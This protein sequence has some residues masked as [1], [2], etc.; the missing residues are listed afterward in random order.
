MSTHVEDHPNLSDGIAEKL[1][2]FGAKIA[3]EDWG[4]GA[5]NGGVNRVSFSDACQIGGSNPDPF[6]TD[7]LQAGPEGDSVGAADDSVKSESYNSRTKHVKPSKS[8]TVFFVKSP[9]LSV[10]D[11]ELSALAFRIYVILIDCSTDKTGG[12]E[13]TIEWLASA[14]GSHK[15]SVIRATRNL[16]EQGYIVK[17]QRAREGMKRANFYG[18]K[19]FKDVPTWK[20]GGASLKI[21]KPPVAGAA[22]VPDTIE[23]PIGE[24]EEPSGAAGAASPSNGSK[25]A[26]G[27]TVAPPVVKPPLAL[28]EPLKQETRA[29]GRPPST[30]QA[31]HAWGVFKTVYRLGQRLDD[32]A[33]RRALYADR[34]DDRTLAIVAD[35]DFRVMLKQ[36]SEWDNKTAF[37]QSYT[38]T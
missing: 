11:K 18:L 37:L 8:E 25:T 14:C 35:P 36:G 10:Y 7:S 27:V 30:G 26:D 13:R 17:K 31:L 3:V 4:G 2:S 32:G 21:V 23:T 20:S 22:G 9:S 12:C 15:N 33:A 28:V 24:S 29:G 34:L 16:E 5:K 19:A 1:A 38:Q 6:V